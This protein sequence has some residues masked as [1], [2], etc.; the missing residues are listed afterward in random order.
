MMPPIGMSLVPLKLPDITFYNESLMYAVGTPVIGM[1]L[2]D[3]LMRAALR[4]LMPSVS[5]R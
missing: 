5:G 4:L 3:V 2:E 1:R